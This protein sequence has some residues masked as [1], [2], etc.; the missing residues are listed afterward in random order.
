[1]R[2]SLVLLTFL[3]LPE[4]GGMQ[5]API[6]RAG[7]PPPR[8]RA[9]VMAVLKD[10]QPVDAAA[11]LPMEIV[12]VSGPKDHGINE[13]DYPQW[14]ERWTRLLGMAPQV[15]VTTANP[16]PTPSQ[17]QTAD[18]VV[19]FSANPAWST[20]RA[21]DLDAFFAR[22]GGLVLQ[23][24]AVN[25]G[26]APEELARRIG[27]AW[28]G[29][30]SKF[31]HGTLDLKFPPGVKHPITAGFTRADLVDESYWNLVGDPRQVNVLATQDEDGAPQPML[32]TYEP[33]KGRMFASLLGHYNWTF[34]DP[35]CRVLMLR[36][37]AWTGNQPIDRFN[38]LVFVGARVSD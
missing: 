20:E 27:L 33:G 37:I 18:C 12:L 38:N 7:A 19:I 29:Q 10:A 17:W 21:G 14:Q 4:P 13:H 3:L 36:G 26:K 22:G 34:D 23:H 24:Y 32:W 15:R 16:W 25:G 1:M 31:R 8:E 5:P 30:H 35:L 2:R 11:L 28:K 6:E 9:A